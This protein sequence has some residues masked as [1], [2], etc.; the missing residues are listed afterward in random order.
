ML[1]RFACALLTAVSLAFVGIGSPAAASGAATASLPPN[2]PAVSVNL[3][4]VVANATR[5]VFVTHAGD[6]RLFIVLRDG[7]IHVVDGGVMLPTPFLTVTDRITTAGEGGLLGLAF[8]PDYATTGRF[9]VYYVNT[10]SNITIERFNRSVG[11]PNVA[12]RATSQVVLVVPHPTFSNHNGGWLGFGPDGFLYAGPGDG[13]AAG[14][15]YCAGQ[16]VQDLRGKLLRLDVVGQV[17]YTTPASNLFTPTQR[18]EVFAIG[19]RNPYRMSF[20]RLTGD[21]YIGDV[22]QDAREEVDRLPSGSAAGA[23]FGWNRFEGSLPY[24]NTCA[25]SGLPHTPPIIEYRHVDE[26]TPGCGVSISG[27][28]VYRGQRYPWLDGTYVYGDFCSGKIWGAWQSAPGVFTTTLITDTTFRLTSFGED[29]QGE[30]YV[31]DYSGNRILRLESSLPHRAY[32]PAI[33]R[34]YPASW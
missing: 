22:G 7:A 23:N 17:T 10:A 30:L 12:D 29:S 28:H 19:L 27:G 31:A 32:L 11:N 5:P 8:E 14:D 4:E 1:S 15:P 26:S 24:S 9:Y 20:D 33:T 2:S 25:S 18:A 16:N 13:G 34:E 21:L 6:D 3:V